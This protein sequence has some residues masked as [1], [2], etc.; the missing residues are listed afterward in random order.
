MELTLGFNAKAADTEAQRGHR[1]SAKLR[2][3]AFLSLR[4]LVAKV[5]L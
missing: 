4:V 5:I 2:V 1:G 3:E